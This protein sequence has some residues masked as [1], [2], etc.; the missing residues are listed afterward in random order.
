M[1]KVQL[2]TAI[3]TQMTDSRNASLEKCRVVLSPELAYEIY[4]YKLTLQ[5]T[6]DFASCFEASGS[7]LKGKSSRLA[8][9]YNVSAKTI[10]DIW[11][12]R[13]WTFATCNLWRDEI[14]K[15]AEVANSFCAPYSQVNK[16][17]VCFS[18]TLARG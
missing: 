7:K 18:L 16:F 13:T 12:R 9:H 11:N 2:S 17:Q 10:R 3:A 8:K 4:A 1:D 6:T 14:A 15:S 5:T